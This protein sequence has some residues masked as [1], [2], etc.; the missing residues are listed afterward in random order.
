[1]TQGWVLAGGVLLIGGCTVI[2][3]PDRSMF[4]GDANQDGGASGFG[5]SAGGNGGGAGAGLRDAGD[6]GGDSAT[7]G[8]DATGGAAPVPLCA[9]GD[10]ENCLVCLPEAEDLRTECAILC[11]QSGEC[12]CSVTYAPLGSRR[13]ATVL[14]TLNLVFVLDRS[15]TMSGARQGFGLDEVWSPITD[16][17]LGFLADPVL[18]Q[19][20]A[21]LVWFPVDGDQDVACDATQYERPVVPLS[22][23]SAA[24]SE[25]F[26]EALASITPQ[27]GSPTVPAFQAAAE[28]ATMIALQ[29]PY[30][31]TALVLITGGEPGYVTDD[32]GEVQ[33]GCE[34]NDFDQLADV[35]RL[36]FETQ[37]P[38]RTYVVGIGGPIEGLDQ[39]AE[40]GGTTTATLVEVGDPETTRDACRNALHQIHETLG[41][42]RLESGTCEL[43]IPGN[44]DTV[45]TAQMRVVVVDPSGMRLLRRVPGCTMDAGWDFVSSSVLED[46]S[47]IELCPATCEAVRSDPTFQLDIGSGCPFILD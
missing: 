8:Q 43:I 6:S 24:G 22:P 1:M 13:R 30:D 39:V 36:A 7:G 29:S 5:A 15:D 3:D 33:L 42:M 27:G 32:T 35:A 37:P 9:P 25:P 14:P 2:T 28:F 41:Q 18:S 19:V 23:L 40:A 20:W 31:R 46:P 44:P 38:V 26:A 21:S 16:G 47:S 34:N 10:S 4:P 17:V 12:S 45:S 11:P